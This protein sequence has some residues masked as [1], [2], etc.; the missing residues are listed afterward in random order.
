MLCGDPAIYHPLLRLGRVERRHCL[1]RRSKQRAGSAMRSLADERSA[2]EP[3][4]TTSQTGRTRPWGDPKVVGD[5]GER[6]VS[7]GVERAAS[8]LEHERLTLC[9]GQP[10]SSPANRRRPM[11]GDDLDRDFVPLRVIPKI[12]DRASA[13]P[14]GFRTVSRPLGGQPRGER[15]RLCRARSM[16]RGGMAAIVPA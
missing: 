13:Y 5:V 6:G 9:V 1:Y 2:D 4:V 14:R 11:D 10:V 3:A 16:H 15:G 12:P 8:I 7:W